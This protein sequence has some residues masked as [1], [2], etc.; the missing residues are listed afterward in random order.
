MISVSGFHQKKRLMF[1][2]VACLCLTLGVAFYGTVAA[3]SDNEVLAVAQLR[4]ID[5]VKKTVSDGS[6]TFISPDGY[7]LT[8]YHV[9]QPA[10]EEEKSV[11]LLCLTLDAR[12]PPQ[13]IPTV[14]NIAAYDEE[15]DLALLKI[16]SVMVKGTQGWTD[17]DTFIKEKGFTV[18][19]VR[20]D[21]TA[22][23]ENISLGEQMQILGYPLAGGRSIT[24]TLGVV[25]G[26]ERKETEEDFM[27]WLIKTDAKLNPGSSGGAAFN[28]ANEYIGVPTLVRGGVG[29]IG[30]IISL[31]VVNEFLAGTGITINTSQ[32]TKK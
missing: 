19:H 18:N 31:P 5:P 21:R 22:T 11:P 6:A 14:I 4:V 12:K 8:N 9:V 30:Y 3:V 23:E 2:G 29:N 27:P 10:L 32:I 26:F 25:S 15:K 24:Y 16:K 28:M 20:F 13:C 1:A 17:F 7:L